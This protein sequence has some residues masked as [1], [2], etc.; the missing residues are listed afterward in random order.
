[1]RSKFGWD[2]PP[3]VTQRQIDEAYGQEGP[4]PVCCKSVDDCICPECPKCESQGDPKCYAHV[5]S[6]ELGHGL[7]L[8]RE[9]AVSRQKARIAQLNDL[10]RDE[11]MYLGHLESG[12]QDIF[13][14][15][16]IPDPFR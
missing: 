11:A 8:T 2:L 3:G 5:R 10:I 14:I 16:D 9:Q 13:D 6:G 12:D 4:C 15:D 1:M 7:K